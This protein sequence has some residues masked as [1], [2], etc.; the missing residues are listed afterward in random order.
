MNGRKYIRNCISVTGLVIFLLAANAS[1]TS[2]TEEPDCLT[3]VEGTQHN[4]L[5][6]YIGK[7]KDIDKNT[8][9]FG[10]FYSA[11]YDLNGDGKPEYFYYIDTPTFCGTGTG[12]Y[13]SVFEYQNNNFRS[14]FKR[15]IPTF[16][17]FQPKLESHKN[18][19]CISNEKT[20]GWKGLKVGS[21]PEYLY[22]EAQQF[23]KNH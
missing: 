17:K 16:F 5:S 1:C 6:E 20:R 21:R 22:D 23:Y 10:H 19:I 14:L 9:K 18:Y 8:V 15:N 11:K 3:F 13:I 7:R 2:Y 12:C 4:R